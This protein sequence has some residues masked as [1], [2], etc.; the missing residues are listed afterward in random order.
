[1]LSILQSYLA[2]NALGILGGVLALV[3]ADFLFG[4]FVSLRAGN[5]NFS[6][7]PQ[8]IQTSLLPYSGGLLLLALFSNVNAE[9]ETLFF[10]IA[11]TVTAKYLA[12]IVSKVG[13]LFAGVTI[14]SPIAVIKSDPESQ[15]KPVPK[16]TQ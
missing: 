9:L 1:M 4:V 6:K 14:Q 11:A 8:F 12:D 7:L 13:T 3:L 5:F 10:T 16:V 2:P 15:S